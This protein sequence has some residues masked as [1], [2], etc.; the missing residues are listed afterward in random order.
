RRENATSNTCTSQALVA[1]MSTIHLTWLG[2]KGLREM[3]EQCY[4]KAHYLATRI[5]TVPGYGVV[6]KDFFNEFVV[7]CAMPPAALGQR[8]LAAGIMG[9][10]DVSDQID[11]G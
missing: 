2:P 5:A 10:L 6:S 4:H 7:R 8:L 1:L 3:A 9:G 11:S